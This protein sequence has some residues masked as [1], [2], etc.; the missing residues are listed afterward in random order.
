MLESLR[1]AAVVLAT[2]TGEGSRAPPRAPA[3][4]IDPSVVRRCWEGSQGSPGP[5][6][7]CRRFLSSNQVL[8]FPLVH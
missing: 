4:C 7:S 8:G 6:V 5:A 3:V 1:S 2:N